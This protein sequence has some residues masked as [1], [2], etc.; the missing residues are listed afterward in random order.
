[1]KIRR[2]AKY[3]ANSAVSIL[4]VV[5]ILGLVNFISNRHHLRSDLTESGRFSLADQ[6]VKVLKGLNRDV[7]VHAFF[8][9]PDRRL[10]DLLDEYKLKS[11]KFNFDFIDPD[12]KPAMAKT[13]DVKKYGAVVVTSGTNVETIFDVDE[14]KMTNAILKVSQDKKKVVYFLTGHDERDIDNIDRLGY[15]AAKKALE[16]ENYEVKKIQ[17]ASD[18]DIPKDCKALMIVSPRVGLFPNEVEKIEKYLDSGGSVLI[19]LDPKPGIGME[20]FLSKWGIN[21][22][23]DIVVDVSGVGR[24]FGAGPTIPLVSDYPSHEITKDFHV[25]TFFPLARSVTPAKK[26]ESSVRAQTILRTNA[27]S[28]AEKDYTKKSFKLDEGV[29]VKG[30]V[31]IAVALTKEI[32]DEADHSKGETA[33]DT[34]KKSARL[35]VFGDSDFA[36][37]SYFSVSGNSDLFLN[38][39]NWLA[40][41]ENLISIRPKEKEDRRVTM[42]QAQTRVVKYFTLVAMP[43]IVVIAGIVVRIRRR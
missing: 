10:E 40:E 43:L 12:R 27:R 38:T 25:M 6:T 34:E 13:Y 19:L 3:G 33:A 28:W 35:V 30:P 7:M 32:K 4:L 37:N 11:G 23:D 21:V 26:H 31:S 14:E 41:E 24:L 20:S 1:L 18:K 9:T 8:Q 2:I 5:G 29:D 42:T 22:G 36:C 39:V 17:L 16:D 15:N